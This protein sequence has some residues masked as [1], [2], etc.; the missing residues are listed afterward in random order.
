MISDKVIHYSGLLSVNLMWCLSVLLLIGSILALPGCLDDSDVVTA[1]ETTATS[2]PLIRTLIAA[3]PTPKSKQPT[4]AVAPASRVAPSASTLTAKSEF[5]AVVSGP[6]HACAIDHRGAITCQGLDSHGQVSEHPDSAGFNAVTVGVNHSCALDH[7]GTILCW[8][9]DEFGQ[10]SP[11]VTDGFIDLEAGDNYTCALHS[12]GDMH[13]W[14]R[15]EPVAKGAPAPTVMPTSALMSTPQQVESSTDPCKIERLTPFTVPFTVPATLDSSW[16]RSDPCLLEIPHALRVTDEVTVD[17]LPGIG[18][19][20][21]QEHYGSIRSP[22]SHSLYKYDTL[23]AINSDGNTWQATLSV[24]V[25]GLYPVLELH[26]YSPQKYEWV[27][28]NTT[29]CGG[30]TILVRY[31]NSVCVEWTPVTETI[32]AVRVSLRRGFTE[33]PFI[34]SYKFAE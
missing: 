15:F 1:V 26:E 18:G 2:T 8:G 31:A 24:P 14:G 34:L 4:P 7:D 32:Y 25:S 13:C 33:S 9:S 6:N 17:T 29:N 12:D 3:S 5:S 21:E 20:H 19:R 16:N 28:V 30:S 23:E 10:S 22:Y 27:P 11:P